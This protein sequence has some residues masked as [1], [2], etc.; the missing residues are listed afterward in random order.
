[1]KVQNTSLINFNA[2]N[3]GK[4]ILSFD[5]YNN[6]RQLVKMWR[7][8]RL[9]LIESAPYGFLFTSRKTLE[10]VSVADK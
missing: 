4:K 10:R 6:T 8:I 2:M 3:L 9:L 5:E 7:P 1:M